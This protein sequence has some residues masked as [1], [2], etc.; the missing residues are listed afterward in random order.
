[1]VLHV[2]LERDCVAREAEV[3][4]TLALSV[5]LNWLFTWLGYTDVLAHT[6][7]DVDN[8]EDGP[9]EGDDA[10]NEGE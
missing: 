2:D 8:G 7:E 5:P 9:V 4:E 1:M 10:E 3:E 6:E